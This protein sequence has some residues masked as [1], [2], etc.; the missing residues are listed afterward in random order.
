MATECIGAFP[1]RLW[2]TLVCSRVGGGELVM[3][4]QDREV[5]LRR[6]G[7]H[8]RNVCIEGQE[9][10]LRVRRPS[11]ASVVAGSQVLVEVA[12]QCRQLGNQIESDR[13]KFSS[14]RLVSAARCVRISST[15]SA[16]CGCN[17]T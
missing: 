1:V 13:A 7:G 8:A 11:S 6:H 9:R 4:S 14:S 16:V 17:A 5:A 10:K 15:I 2:C 3:D 12:L